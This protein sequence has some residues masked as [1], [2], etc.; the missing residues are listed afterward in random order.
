[1][2][3]SEGS[4]TKL[5]SANCCLLSKLPGTFPVPIV[6]VQ[7]MPAAYVSSLV[8]R[9]NDLSELEVLETSDRMRIR[10]GAVY[11]A[12]G[13]VH[14]SIIAP[15]GINPEDAQRTFD[16]FRGDVFQF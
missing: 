1:M 3:T 8:T 11:V 7:H 4:L 15:L 10:P 14:T 16:A 13:G 2:R 9:L 12:A 6:V 5:C